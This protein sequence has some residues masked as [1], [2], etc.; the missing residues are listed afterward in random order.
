MW[1]DDAN[2]LDMLIAARH[3]AAFSRDL[4]WEQFQG[5]RLHQHAITK[6]LENI[7]EAAGKVSSETKKAHPE[8]PWPQIVGLRHR[9]A[10][11]YFR[12]DLLRVWEIVTTDVPTLIITLEPL[13]PPEE[14]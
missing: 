7:G 10:H 8:I 1:R 11:D 14:P 5:S 13:V 4:T 12:L 3:A 2:L 6:A 9:I